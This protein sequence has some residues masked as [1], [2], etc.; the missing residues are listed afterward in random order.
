MM[1]TPQFVLLQW[2]ISELGSL[3]AFLQSS[4]M[5]IEADGREHQWRDV[6]IELFTA[7]E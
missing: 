4:E 1:A 6:C 3:C 7:D 2:T 5:N